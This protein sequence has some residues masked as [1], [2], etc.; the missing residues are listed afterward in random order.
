MTKKW[1]KIEKPKQKTKTIKGS[2]HTDLEEK[3]LMHQ[4]KQ[5]TFGYDYPLTEPLT[6]DIYNQD[7]ICIMG[8]N[9]SG[10]T[11]LIQCLKD[12]K[13][14]ISGE[15]HDVRDL[16]YFYFD[17]NQELLDPSMTLFDTIHEEFP[18]MTNTEVRTLLGRFLFVEDDVFK[19][20]SQLSGGEK[21]RL[22]F[23]L[24]SL[25]KY[26]I[27]YLDEP[28]NH[29]D[30]TTKEVVAD[31]LEDYQGTIIM[32]SH[33]RYFI[34]R[35]ANK[36]IYLQNKKFIIEPGNYEHFL[37]LHQIENNQFTYALKKQKNDS[38]EKNLLNE[39][40]ENKKEIEKI[41]KE[42]LKKV[43]EAG[44]EI[45]N[46]FFKHDNIHK[47]TEQ[48]I[49]ES[50]VKNNELIKEAVGVTPKLVRP[51]YGIVTDTLKKVCKELDMDII[52]WN[53]DSKDWDKTPDS[54][55]IKNMLKSPA[56]GDIM[57][58]HDGSK[59]YTNTL[60]SLDVI[61]PSLQKKKFEFVTISNLLDQ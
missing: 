13:H 3:V 18:L 55:I 60:S 48:E 17:Q 14:K 53:K 40:K 27:L 11:T 7:K 61:I 28:T 33:D 38:K 56:N 24:I 19:T 4:T 54:T 37:S 6:L 9:G 34:N 58:F 2:F 43:V 20:V 31:I 49:R 35:V 46:H 51:P 45:G 25:R 47:L 15:N 12:N 16:R 1:K 5:L 59:T 21:V 10:K 29:L 57:L 41:E 23:A 8:Q 39:K 32:V 44:H 26:Q 52:L 50:I 22:I 36:I 42:M 30:F